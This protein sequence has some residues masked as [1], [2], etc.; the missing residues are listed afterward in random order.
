[1]KMRWQPSLQIIPH[2]ESEPLYINALV[3]SIEKK[4]SEINWKPDLIVSS[5]HGIPK[6]YFEKGDPYHCY[7]HKTTRLMKEKF[8]KIEIQTTFQSRFGPQEWLTPYVDE[9]SY[10]DCQIEIG[11]FVKQNESFYKKLNI[12]RTASR[13]INIL[14]FQN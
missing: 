7:C 11:K 4:I 6:S 3:N 5:Y 14:D 13:A 10:K 8:K 2:Y 12:K 1:M 9:K